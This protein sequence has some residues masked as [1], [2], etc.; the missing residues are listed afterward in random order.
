MDS[1]KLDDWNHLI[2]EVC[3][4]MSKLTGN[5]FSSKQLPMVESRVKRR[6]LDLDLDS[7]DAYRSYWRQHF[8]AENEFLV[9]LLTTH[10]TSFFREFSHF[11]W[12]AENLPSI[13]AKARA[14]GRSTL[15]FWSAA[16]SRGQE[17]WSLAMWFVPPRLPGLDIPIVS[18]AL[19]RHG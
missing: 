7:V 5:V 17:V 14:E 16:C 10:F 18:F 9:G 13:M 4:E 8:E 11:E 15:F 2:K 1:F 3:E 19:N 6:I 12:I